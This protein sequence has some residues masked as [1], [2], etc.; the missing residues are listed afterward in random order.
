[1]F[2]ACGDFLDDFNFQSFCVVDFFAIVSTAFVVPVYHL[3]GLR[4]K[5][6]RS[7]DA[8]SCLEASNYYIALPLRCQCVYI[9][10]DIQTLSGQERIRQRENW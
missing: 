1:M 4:E 2:F 3:L 5:F 7:N 9:G 6:K 10:W 8:L